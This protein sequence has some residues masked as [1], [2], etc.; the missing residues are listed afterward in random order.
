GPLPELMCDILAYIPKPALTLDCPME[1]IIID[2]EEEP[3]FIFMKDD[4]VYGVSKRDELIVLAQMS[5]GE[6]F[7]LVRAPRS[8]YRSHNYCYYNA[9]YYY[10][11]EASHL[12]V[13][14]DGGGE[15]INDTEIR[16]TVSLLEYDLKACEVD[17]TAALPSLSGVG[18]FP[19]SMVIIDSAIFLG[20]EWGRCSADP[21]RSIELLYL[22]PL[23]KA[24]VVWHIYDKNVKLIGLHRV[25]ASPMV[26]DVIYSEGDIYHSVRLEM[27]RTG[28]SILAEERCRSHA[29]M[30]EDPSFFGGGVLMVRSASSY[31]LFDSRLRKVSSEITIPGNPECLFFVD[32]GHGRFHF[33]IRRQVASRTR[34]GLLRAFPYLN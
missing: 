8:H 13:L 10:D 1:E 5:H 34:Y 9:A 14:H 4:D 30:N 7:D 29:Q 26:L 31:T 22:D 28:T 21:G 12:Y 25:S 3:D 24:R 17:R 15:S 33:L 19:R 2:I 20:I 32:D 6:C 18:E 11:S 27:R 23:R 16:G